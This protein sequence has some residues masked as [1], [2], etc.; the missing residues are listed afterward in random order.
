MMVRGLSTITTNSRVISKEQKMLA[1]WKHWQDKRRL[2]PIVRILPHV[3]LSWYG[4]QKFYTAAQVKKA[5]EALKLTKDDEARA[6]A[7]SCNESEFHAAQPN[8]TSDAYQVRRTEIAKL[9]G[10]SK[11]QFTCLDL[12]AL[13]RPPRSALWAPLNPLNDSISQDGG[14]HWPSAD[15]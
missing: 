15:S 14:T 1:W 11:Q 10:L 13:G 6:Y 4:G 7:I 2:R 8:E 5:L 12:R 3:L 9:F